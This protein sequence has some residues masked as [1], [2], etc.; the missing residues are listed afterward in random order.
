MLSVSTLLATIDT[1]S[2]MPSSPDPA[3]IT[4]LSS[5]GTLLISD[6]EVNETGIYAGVN[7]YES[8]LSGGLV[9]TADTTTYSN[10]PTG[11]TWNPSNDHLFFSDDNAKEVFERAPGVD[12]LLFT[13]DDVIT[14]F[15]TVVFGSDDPEGIAYD[16]LNDSLFIVDGVTQEVYHVMPGV[17][18]IFDGI[19]PAGDDIVTTRGRV[20]DRTYQGSFIRYELA[21]GDLSL[22]AEAVNRPDLAVYEPGSE[23]GVSWHK[24][25]CSVLTD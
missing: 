11:V 2:F 7:L 3:G 23:I 20:A 21:I 9:G 14:S 10:E 18:G 5:T 12:E 1:S 8:T 25:S 16:T 22:V 4:Y 24:K 17:N 6:S 19:A 13:S 15:D